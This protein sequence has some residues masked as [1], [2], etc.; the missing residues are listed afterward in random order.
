[1]EK[2][3]EEEVLSTPSTLSE[4]KF[5]QYLAGWFVRQTFN[6]HL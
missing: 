4:K 6:S 3:Q 5:Q 1:M 2:C